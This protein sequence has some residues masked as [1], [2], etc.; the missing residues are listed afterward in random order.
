MKRLPLFFSLLIAGLVLVGADG[1][2][3]DPN[4]EGAKLDIRNKDYD[5]AVENLDKA[6]ESNPENVEA[7]TMMGNV[8]L[9]KAMESTDPAEHTSF[10]ERMVDSYNRAAALQGDVQQNLDIAYAREFERA[11]QTFNRGQNDDSMY[12]VAAGYFANVSKIRPDSAAPYTYAGYASLNAGDT[13]AA[14][15]ALEKAVEMGETDLQAYL[16]LGDLY[17]SEGS[18]EKSVAL[19]EG[20]ESM[21]PG[22]ADLQAQLLSAYQEAGMMDRAM[23]KYESSI[24]SDPNNKT[25]RYNYGSLLL[26]AGEYDEAIVHL[27]RATELDPEYSFAWYNLGAAHQN[28]AVGYNEEVTKLDDDLRENKPNMS[29]EAIREVET[30]MDE[31]AELRRAS[32]QD[33]IMPLETA[34][35]LT[36]AEGGDVTGMCVALYTAYVQTDQLDKAQGVSACAG[37]DE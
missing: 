31:L 29:P 15:S 18:P 37:F 27:T 14:I 22:D 2:S 24:E 17:R 6:L 28:K 11:V 7:L 19:L 9:E 8:M 32:F 4:V 16:F 26:Q 5:R 30:Q 13:P 12:G 23:T 3:S 33:A 36:E 10:I 25:Y 34:K 35:Q 20:A 21:F 1:C